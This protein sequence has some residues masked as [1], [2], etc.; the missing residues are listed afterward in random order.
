[1]DLDVKSAELAPMSSLQ[2]SLVTIK[3]WIDSLY[4]KMDED[5]AEYIQFGSRKQLLK[6]NC[7]NISV[8]GSTIKTFKKIKFLGLYI[9]ETL[10][11][12]DHI[13]IKCF[14]A[15]KNIQYITSIRKHIYLQK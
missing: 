15:S 3:T 9:D 13:Q 8:I 10:T 11:C 12:K 4:V 14:T 1:M 5:K 7:D 6:C 2:Q